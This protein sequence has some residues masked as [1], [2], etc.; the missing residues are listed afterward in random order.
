MKTVT[1][2]IILAILLFVVAGATWSQAKQARQM[3][4]AHERLATLHYDTDDR[5]DDTSVWN[6]LP[7]PIGNG[8]DEVKRYRATVS[9]WL[10]HFDS[11]SELSS[12]TGTQAV[13]DPQQL[14]VAANASWRQVPPPDDRKVTL[15]RLDG[16][17]QAYA[18]VLRR[19]GGLT[20]AAYNYEFVT[21][22]RD[23]LAKL[24]AR[25]TSARG[26]KPAESLAP[27]RT[28]DMSGD[29]PAGVTIH[30]RP[31]GPPE[32]TDMSDFKTISPM[33][34]DEREEQMD[35]GRGKEIR[36]KG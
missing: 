32:G 35:P 12:V 25:R 7:W 31:G 10:S 11:L 19:D 24:P 6:R 9:Y 5:I 2:G 16:V 29:L 14:L 30:G 20:D 3:A 34:Y 28:D 27:K 15:D 22:V 17:I 1:G 23:T 4:T 36:R 21:R 33:R 8:A 13:S 18:D 26:E